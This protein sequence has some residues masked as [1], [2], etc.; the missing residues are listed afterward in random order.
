M[1]I[2]SGYVEELSFLII[3]VKI[4]LVAFTGTQKALK[5]SVVPVKLDITRL[6]YI[7]C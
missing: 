2:K 7:F 5:A 6:V 3:K 1:S 4:E